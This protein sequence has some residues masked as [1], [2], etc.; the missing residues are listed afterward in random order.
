VVKYE[1][2]RDEDNNPLFDE[3][4]NPVFKPVGDLTATC[5]YSAVP[6]LQSLQ[7][8]V[9]RVLRENNMITGSALED[10]AARQRKDYVYGLKAG[11]MW[12]TSKE[13]LLKNRLVD[14]FENEDIGRDESNFMAEA[15]CRYYE[16]ALD[17]FVNKYGLLTPAEAYAIRSR[18]T[19]FNFSNLAARLKLY[20]KA[21]KDR[22]NEDSCGAP[23]TAIH[24]LLKRLFP[25]AE[26]DRLLS[27]GHSISMIAEMIYYSGM[28][29]GMNILDN[30]QT[31]IEQTRGMRNFPGFMVKKTIRRYGIDSLEYA[32]VIFKKINDAIDEIEEAPVTEQDFSGIVDD[33]KHLLSVLSGINNGYINEY[34]GI[35]DEFTVL[36]DASKLVFADKEADELY[37]DKR[38]EIYDVLKRAYGLGF[39]HSFAYYCVLN[40]GLSDA[41][42]IAGEV[43]RLIDSPEAK[44]Q[45]LA[46][47]FCEQIYMQKGYEGLKDF[48]R[49][50]SSI[51]HELEKMGFT[52][53]EARE[54]FRYK[55]SNIVNELKRYEKVG[56]DG[57]KKSLLQ[58]LIDLGLQ[59]HLA[60]KI[61]KKNKIKNV[62][63]VGKKTKE[64]YDILTK[65]IAEGG[66]YGFSKASANILLYTLV[67]N[68]ALAV[69][70]DIK[71]KID[72][73]TKP[74]AEGGLYGYSNR[75]MLVEFVLKYKDKSYE[76]AAD[77]R[78]TVS[79]IVNLG[80]SEG[81]ALTM[82]MRY[83]DNLYALKHAQDMA[84]LANSL[85][86]KG[87]R[88]YKGFPC[89]VYRW[90]TFHSFDEIGELLKRVTA[91][92][93]ENGQIAENI[94]LKVLSDIKSEL[95]TFEEGQEDSELSDILGNMEEIIDNDQNIQKG[96]GSISADTLHE[97]C[98]SGKYPTT[99]IYDRGKDIP[100]EDDYPCNRR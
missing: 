93:I 13:G 59:H 95:I 71:T 55:N 65:P 99:I 22:I 53:S 54:L 69:A 60:F 35:Q 66:L 94:M 57:T 15:L 70:S 40:A 20:V 64:T 28:V 78:D 41:K 61:I 50:G 87:F 83:E 79:A 84:A 68:E 9:W 89:D 39:S 14:F 74:I 36:T 44:K 51:I 47:W 29:R 18:N 4:G 100:A 48:I 24:K 11:N 46:H 72:T 43:K 97:V 88:C 91:R 52:L 77:K 58:Q 8:A 42:N 56:K 92:F 5:R 86:E 62:L 67:Y 98:T 25:V 49:D 90:C 10:M 37:S 2:K 17:L 73:L 31:I 96:A 76:K 82:V 81:S 19:R 21:Y 75:G 23:K 45:G 26:Y 63:S 7:Q 27:E 1:Q 34:G 38:K 85:I 16:G 33:P 30:T 6:A 3:N 32:E 12:P 80:F